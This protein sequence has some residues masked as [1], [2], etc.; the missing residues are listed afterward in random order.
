[1]THPERVWKLDGHMD[2]I[3]PITRKNWEKRLLW[4]THT[5]DTAFDTA[6]EAKRVMIQR[7]EAAHT[8]AVNAIKPAERR[9]AKCRAYEVKS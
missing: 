4:L 3:T 9:V 6:E 7:A 8:A 2:K 5:R 1:M